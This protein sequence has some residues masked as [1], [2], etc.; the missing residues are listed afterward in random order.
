MIKTS[1][2]IKCARVNNSKSP[3]WPYPKNPSEKNDD[4]E[5]GVK[6]I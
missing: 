4:V 2:G 1:T 5:A 6:F 3:F